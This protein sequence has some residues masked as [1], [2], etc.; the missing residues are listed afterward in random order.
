[1]YMAYIH[2]LK[3]TKVFKVIISLSLQT[4]QRISCSHNR[5][6][7]VSVHWC[8]NWVTGGGGVELT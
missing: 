2:Y 6:Q 8:R 5:M 3:T 1:M 4:K 7:M